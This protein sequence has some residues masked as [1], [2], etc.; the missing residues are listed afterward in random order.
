MFVAQD[1]IPIVLILIGIGLSIYLVVLARRAMIDCN[2]VTNN[3]KRLSMHSVFSTPSEVTQWPLELTAAWIERAPRR[4]P[5]YVKE[6]PATVFELL[7]EPIVPFIIDEI[8]TPL[9]NA[10][11]SVVAGE[12]A[13]NNALMVIGDVQKE[14]IVLS[15]KCGAIALQIAALG[16]AV[17]DAKKQSG[18]D[19]TAALDVAKHNLIEADR[20]YQALRDNMNT[21]MR[22]LESLVVA[23]NLH[24]VKK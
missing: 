19:E 5:P 4:V 9:N 6:H 8:Q 10:L 24:K 22:V 18:D 15:R 1:V 21:S 2:E 17:L 3:L 16:Q 23:V 13:V 14:F 12:D 7:E 11:L 20:R